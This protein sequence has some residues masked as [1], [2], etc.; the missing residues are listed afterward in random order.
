MQRHAHYS[1]E[2]NIAQKSS[3]F[4]HILPLTKYLL[5]K[6]KYTGVPYSEKKLILTEA[7]CKGKL[8]LT[9]IKA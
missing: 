3:Y 5:R 4:T 2:N 7:I 8:M 1:M 9:S 6:K